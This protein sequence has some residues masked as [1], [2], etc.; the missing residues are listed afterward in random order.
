MPELPTR[1]QQPSPVNPQ[2][3][4][5]GEFPAIPKEVL[6]RF[7][8]AKDWQVR[9]DEFWGRTAQALQESQKQTAAQVNSTVIW[10]VDRFLIYTSNGGS[11]PMFELDDTG[12]RLGHVLVIN[13]PGRKVYIG[14]GVY[15]DDQTPFYIDAIGRFS[16]GASLVWDPDTDTLTI[17]G[18]I[19]ATS[20]TIGGFDIG[21]DYIRDVANSMGLASTVTGFPDVRFWAGDTFANR[22]TAPLRLYEDGAANIG[23]LTVL[24][25]GNVGISTSNPIDTGLTVVENI[26]QKGDRDLIHYFDDRSAAGIR[27]IA[28]SWQRIGVERWLVGL[29]PSDD[30]FHFASGGVPAP[31]KVLTLV[32]STGIANFIFGLNSPSIGSTTPGTGAFTS[33]NTTTGAVVVGTTAGSPIVQFGGTTAAYPAARYDA[34]GRLG[35]VL[36]DQSAYAD[37]QAA[38]ATFTAMAVSG[39]AGVGTRNVV[40]DA[41]GV[42]SAP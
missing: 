15:A 38:A 37:I 5:P 11:M 12:I 1:R 8:S 17:T 3:P 21:A 35:I 22:A 41:A 28:L 4:I 6:D 9:L 24:A 31:G 20:G 7:S 2:V 26:W 40:V 23:S 13:T 10:T 29:Q 27:Y 42:M 33:L 19:N 36:A 39:L 30:D 18:I 25:N 34:P 32:Y 16:L 14:A